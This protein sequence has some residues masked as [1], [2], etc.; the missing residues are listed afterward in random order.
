MQFKPLL[1]QNIKL[2]FSA[3]IGLMLFL[4]SSSPYLAQ[5]NAGNNLLSLTV[6]IKNKHN[7][8]FKLCMLVEDGI[9]F[10]AE[11]KNGLSKSKFVG[12]LRKAEN[13][14]YLLKFS[15]EQ[16]SQKGKSKT[17]SGDAEEPELKL[18]EQYN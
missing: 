10:R 9:P 3:V 18:D 1:N 11:W 17:K 15:L 16:F 12:A 6:N 4:C 8:D 13:G 2:T 7:P 5:T 14:N